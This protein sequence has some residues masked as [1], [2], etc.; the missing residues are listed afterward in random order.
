MKLFCIP[1]AGRSAKV[2]SELK[3]II[4]DSIEVVSIKLLGRWTII[5]R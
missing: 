4:N 2:Y 3:N 5:A 1:Y